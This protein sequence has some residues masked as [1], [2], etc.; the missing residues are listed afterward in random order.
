MSSLRQRPSVNAGTHATAPDMA[1]PRPQAKPRHSV[2]D[3]GSRTRIAGTRSSTAV[4]W[5][6]YANRLRLTDAAVVA[7]SIACAYLV[8][9]GADA[10]GTGG[11]HFEARYLWVSGLMIAA[12]IAALEIY[13]T[14]DGRTFG[15]GADEYKRVAQATLKLFGALAIAMVVLRLDVVR[16]YFAIALPLGLLLLCGNRWL[17]RKW[18]NRQRR[19]G[20]YLSKVIVIGNP[21]DVEYV[22]NQISGNPCVGYQVSGVALSTLLESM[23]LK[24]P[25]YRI[26]VLSTLA[27]VSRMVAVTGADAVIVAGQVPGGSKYIRELGWR[28]EETGTELVLASTLT[29]VAGPRIHWRQVEGLP[30]V[31]VELPQYAGGKHVLKRAVDILVSAMALLV[32]SPLMLALAVI[33]KRDSAGPVIFRQERVGRNGV[34][35]HMLKFRSMAQNAEEDLESLLARNEGSGPL[36]KIRNDPRVTACGRWMRKYSLDELPQFWNVL[37]GE[38]SLVGPRPPLHQEVQEYEHFTNRRLLIKPGITGLWQINGRSNL[39]WE[40]SIR[41]DLYYVENWSLTGDL[42]IMWRTFRAMRSPVGAF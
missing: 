4:R 40:E 24:P 2:W 34:P 28:L 11:Q 3:D 17:W 22:V 21:S 16:G 10:Q 33:V 36:F 6:D 1:W 42:M 14:R 37:V 38:M 29:N 27:D 18:L 9:F 13:R 30:L 39:P 7:I 20:Q 15:V 19:S 8:R 31:H 26:P 41:L 35:F 23:E 12:W 25:W 5:T 32:L